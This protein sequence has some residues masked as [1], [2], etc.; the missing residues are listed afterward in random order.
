MV[1]LPKIS[2]EFESVDV[3]VT[4]SLVE[5]ARTVPKILGPSALTLIIFAG[6]ITWPALYWLQINNFL[7]ST[8]RLGW[9]NRLLKGG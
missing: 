7:T 4:Q 1:F 2:T 6:T 3:L 9:I 5:L 8:L